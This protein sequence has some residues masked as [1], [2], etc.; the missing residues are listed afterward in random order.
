M[1]PLWIIDITKPSDRRDAFLHLVGQIDHVLIPR[2]KYS[3]AWSDGA[4]EYNSERNDDGSNSDTGCYS[5][6]DYAVNAPKIFSDDNVNSEEE[7]KAA[8]NAK[9]TG[10]Y[11]YYSSYEFEDSFTKSDLNE[12]ITDFRFIEK[13]EVKGDA[14]ATEQLR[15]DA[16]AKK[17]LRLKE[18]AEHLYDFQNKL[19]EDAKAFVMALRDSNA[20]PYQPINIVVLGDATE[21]FTQLVFPSIAAI[22]EKE[23]GRFLAGHIHQGMSIIGMLYVPCNINAYKVEERMRVLRLLKEVEVQHKITSMR[24]YDNMM[25]YQDV[26]NRTE[27]T[28]R[29]LKP[30]ELAEYLVQCLVNMYLA[31]DI[32]HPL[33]SGTGSD[34]V[35][36]F[37]MGATSIYFDMTV[38]DK[39]DA[40]LVAANILK[41]FKENGDYEKTEIEV[42][43]YHREDIA[44]ETFVNK[45]E[46]S[47]VDISD[48]DDMREPNPHPI[49]DFFHRNLKRL[50]YEFYLRFFPAELLRD[51]MQRIE[52]STNRQLENISVHSVSSFKNCQMA[53]PSSID[54][55]LSKTNKNVGGLS[56][57]ENK[58]RDMQEAVSKEKNNI[59][60]AINSIYWNDILEKHDS[61]FDDYHDTYRNDIRLKNS[62]AGCNGMKQEVLGRL[63]ELLSKEKTLL[64]VIFRCLFLG[65]INVLAVLPILNA[66]SPELIDLGDV[67]D[68]RYLWGTLLFIIP[69]IALLI[70]HFINLRNKRNLIHLLKTYYTHDAYARLAN[71]IES[72]AVSFYDKVLA[73]LDE[74]LNRC[75]RIRNEVNI[76]TPDPTLK[77]LFPKGKFN[78]PL[79]GGEFDDEPLIS[80]ADIKCSSIKINNK[81]VLVNC[82]TKEQYY[83]LLNKFKSEFA[84]LFDGVS[85]I[86]SHARRF[87]EKIGDYVFEGRDEILKR[88][89]EHWKDLK[90]QFNTELFKC[91]KENM[92]PREFPTIGEKLLQYSKKSDNCTILEYMIAYAATNGEF[93][94]ENDTEYADVKMNR[95]IKSLVSRYLPTYTTKEQLSEF[96]E[97]FKRYL[98]VTRWQTYKDLALNRLFPEEDFDV[99]TR[100]ERVFE[101]ETAKKA[102]AEERSKNNKSKNTDANKNEKDADKEYPAPILSSIMLWS[103]CPDENSI[104]W[105][106]LFEVGHFDVAYRQRQ[107]FREV[108]NQND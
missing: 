86:D 22:L 26:Q 13:L 69:A 72:E 27:C 97:I 21:E 15:K 68:Y 83:I 10:N 54:R 108:M 18:A 44:A 102:K 105:L 17:E 58:F 80:P 48:G 36:Y 29:R 14:A 24:G 64:S 47:D 30:A 57:I 74:Y 1:L 16:Q 19:V 4:A 49:S 45:F 65:I 11:W 81:P 85:L 7:R 28:Y 106:K 40:N 71:R 75:K 66:I 84:Q 43:L 61:S 101:D 107:I 42:E 31:C 76:V 78:Q 8:R 2:P 67:Y 12:D 95:D 34:D 46:V 33:L 79:N 100:E 53:L 94:S 50:Y 99:N 70:S 52:D 90:M 82:I 55:V 92:L 87:D 39:N 63:K 77:L 35:F 23:K 91:I 96:D 51:T 41:T 9:I 6:N 73:L 38:E 25:L 62:G 3:A 60:R 88:K 37:S 59:Q 20:K 93:A 5:E 104:E 56:F 89:E 32:N 98:F 103:V